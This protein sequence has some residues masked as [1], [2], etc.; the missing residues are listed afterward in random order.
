MTTFAHCR[1]VLQTG[2]ILPRFQG[3]SYYEAV[4]YPNFLENTL[5]ALDSDLRYVFVRL[6]P[7]LV[8]VD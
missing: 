8:L 7:V 5:Q 6:L 3:M 4:P 1:C 2:L